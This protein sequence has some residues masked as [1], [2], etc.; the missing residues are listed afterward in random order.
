MH[1]SI[2]CVLCDSTIAQTNV[3]YPVLVTYGIP[4]NA[5]IPVQ[6]TKVERA[7]HNGS[8]SVDAL[9]S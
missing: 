6:Y 8:C 9:M 2:A 1:A 3:V 7:V 4:N 5:I